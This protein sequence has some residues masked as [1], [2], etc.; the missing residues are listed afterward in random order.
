MAARQLSSQ[1]QFQQAWRNLERYNAGV[2]SGTMRSGENEC[3]ALGS[4]YQLPE[5]EQAGCPEGSTLDLTPGNFPRGLGPLPC[6]FDP[7]AATKKSRVA[8]ATTTAAPARVAS[9]MG[10]SAPSFLNYQAIAGTSGGGGSVVPSFVTLATRVAA[11]APR[12][13]KKGFPKYSE[14]V[15]QALRLRYRGQPSGRCLYQPGQSLWS[16]ILGCPPAQEAFIEADGQP[17]CRSPRTTVATSY[18]TL[19]TER[20]TSQLYNTINRMAR[21]ADA[22]RDQLDIASLINANGD[23]TNELYQY[24]P[25]SE[26]KELYE[27][28]RN[29]FQQ[30][31]D[32]LRIYLS[33]EMTSQLSG[34]AIPKEARII[35]FLN[36]HVSNTLKLVPKIYNNSFAQALY[37]LTEQTTDTLRRLTTITPKLKASSTL[38]PIRS[39][40]ESL[41]NNARALIPFLAQFSTALQ[42]RITQLN[43]MIRPATLPLPVPSPPL[44]S[45]TPPARPMKRPSA[46]MQPKV[47]QPQPAG[48]AIPVPSAATS[49]GATMTMEEI[50]AIVNAA[51]PRAPDVFGIQPPVAGGGGPGSALTRLLAGPTLPIVGATGRAKRSRPTSMATTVKLMNLVGRAGD[52]LSK[53]EVNRSPCYEHMR[54]LEE[55][56]VDP[57]VL[58]PWQ[59]EVIQTLLVRRGAIAYHSYGS[60]KTLTAC[61]AI[62]CLLQGT[63]I[64]DVIIV[65]IPATFQ[66]TWLPE[67]KR[68]GYPPNYR[69]QIVDESKDMPGARTAEE[70]AGNIKRIFIMSVNIL[71]ALQT[72][73]RLNCDNTFLIVD[74]AHHQKGEQ[75]AGSAAAVNRSTARSRLLNK[76]VAGAATKS[77]KGAT[78]G[79][80]VQA[81]SVLKCANKMRAAKVL[82]MTGSAIPDKPYD[83]ANLI[84]I[85]TG[86]LPLTKAMFNNLIGLY[87]EGNAEPLRRYLSCIVSYHNI[88]WRTEVKPD[89]KIG[90]PAVITHPTIRVTM[91]DDYLEEYDKVERGKINELKYQN[92]AGVRVDTDPKKFYTGL[93]I[94]SNNIY[95][96][97]KSNPKV[98][99]IVKIINDNAKKGKRKV[100]VYSAF[101]ASGIGPFADFLDDQ[102]GAPRVKLIPTEEMKKNPLTGN[103][104]PTISYKREGKGTNSDTKRAYVEINGQTPGW[105]RELGIARYNSE[106]GKNKILLNTS[107]KSITTVPFDYV[108][109]EEQ[110][111]TGM[112]KLFDPVNIILLG[113]AGSEGIN[114]KRTRVEIILE[115]DWNQSKMDQAIARGARSRSHAPPMPYEDRTID[116]Y[117]IVLEKPKNWRDILI[118]RQ[119][120]EARAKI[121]AS[122]AYQRLIGRT[123]LELGVDSALEEM[124]IKKQIDLDH[125]DRIIAEN[126]IGRHPEC[127]AG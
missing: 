84:A 120:F 108:I 4:F 101:V 59:K 24:F 14:G 52:G 19:A 69:I 89:R 94:A 45:M 6:C 76:M 5:S 51:P 116:L 81:A 82:V 57:I 90:Y 54:A 107:D 88:S 33:Q 103:V 109:P 80:A 67:M 29:N 126:S 40:I 53:I 7:R 37:Q 27:D 96:A 78:K 8:T 86:E 18:D 102:F 70:V 85:A 93:R 20:T 123:V 39:E 36:Q 117:Y 58:D 110:K 83:F 2:A 30:E 17:C 31:R 16:P 61:M 46:A 11:P 56:K 114:L 121:D 12:E 62:Y 65:G 44:T 125:F 124:H 35:G 63:D 64:N 23:P 106:Y 100:M 75:R 118:G 55:R 98:N 13:E 87:N 74:E 112:W 32:R 115:P 1:E 47:E 60:G 50:M 113:P 95:I 21:I 97:G 99:E 79:M 25:P 77:V 28:A 48:P 38:L 119:G 26:A 10:P 49:S 72:S 3:S 91:P 105:E 92:K 15:K 73:N 111:I 66:T 104:E 42:S 34:V 68:M 22:V 122:P 9:V 127:L 71:H 43:S 41:E